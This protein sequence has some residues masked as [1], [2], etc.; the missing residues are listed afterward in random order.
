MAPPGLKRP[1]LGRRNAFNATWLEAARRLSSRVLLDLLRWSG[2]QTYA[3]YASLDP[4]T[5][6]GPV[7]WVDPE[8]APSWLEIDREYTERWVHHQ[9]IREALGAA[10][11]TD[12]RPG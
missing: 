1:M 11:L 4:R 5:V 10:P 6:G 3:Y 8:P 9:Q 7:E 2:E 12:D